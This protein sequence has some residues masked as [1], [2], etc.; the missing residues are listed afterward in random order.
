MIDFSLLLDSHVAQKATEMAGRHMPHIRFFGTNWW[1]VHITLI[2]CVSVVTTILIIALAVLRWQKNNKETESVREELEQTKVE[3]EKK[4]EEL[5]N[6]EKKLSAMEHDPSVQ[7]YALF[8]DICN[9]SKNK[10]GVV[11]IVTFQKLFDLFKNYKDNP[12]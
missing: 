12:S 4:E 8:K 6:A 3:L 11:D 1:D 7:Y 5:K 9:M 2:I 10:E